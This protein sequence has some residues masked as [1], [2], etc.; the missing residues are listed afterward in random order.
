MYEL[1]LGN[2]SGLVWMR[3]VCEG[4]VICKEQ[5]NLWAELD[6][7]MHQ[8]S[9]AF[10]DSAHLIFF[11]WGERV[12]T[13]ELD[14][15]VVCMP[16]MLQPSTTWMDVAFFVSGGHR[17]QSNSDSHFHYRLNL[18]FC[19]RSACRVPSVVGQVAIRL[20]AVPTPTHPSSLSARQ[21]IVG[22]L[23]FL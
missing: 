5:V 1:F 12:M 2:A 7:H 14:S 19:S 9:M 23:L 17:V 10:T 21:N 4:L 18:S 6:M 22:F 3:L 11:V 20:A 13:D 15:L 8:V 16:D